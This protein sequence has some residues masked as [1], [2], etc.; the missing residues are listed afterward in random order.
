MFL[1]G[2]QECLRWHQS[3]CPPDAWGEGPGASPESAREALGALIL[4]LKP[5]RHSHLKAE[6]SRVGPGAGRR[7][8]GRGSPLRLVARPL[9]VGLLEPS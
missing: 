3:P 4:G 8:P 1:A 9:P 7:E 6:G 2:P 5:T